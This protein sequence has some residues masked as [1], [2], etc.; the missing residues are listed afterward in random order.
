M[1]L[2]LGAN[3]LDLRTRAAGE[4]ARAMRRLPTANVNKQIVGASDNVSADCLA[5]R[6]K[7]LVPLRRMQ[8]RFVDKVISFEYDAGHTAPAA[9]LAFSYSL[10][11]FLYFKQASHCEILSLLSFG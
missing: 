4:V 6:I 2:C 11:D 3:R 8:H 7:C 9:S 5:L 1:H 10:D